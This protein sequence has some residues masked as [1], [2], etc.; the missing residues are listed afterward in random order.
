MSSSE[1][2]PGAT[3]LPVEGGAVSSPRGGANGGDVIRLDPN[4]NRTAANSTTPGNISN[5]PLAFAQ[6]PTGGWQGPNVQ[7]VNAN[8]SIKTN[9]PGGNDITRE[10]VDR[11]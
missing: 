4:N 5:P 7:R 3:P 1:T 8:P 9:T 10:A 2:Q 6:G 11:I